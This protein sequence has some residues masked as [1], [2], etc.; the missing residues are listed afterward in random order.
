MGKDGQRQPKRESERVR[1][2]LLHRY[3]DLS[4]K[5]LHILV[6]L[7]PLLLLYEAGSLVYL[8]DH[9]TGAVE[10]IRAYKILTDLFG[11][12][13]I[14]GLYLLYLPGL[15]L[16][17]VLLA[18]HIGARESW[19]PRG[20]VVA[21]MWLESILLMLPLLVFS[22]LIARL[23]SL[24][25]GL[26]QPGASLAE[27]TAVQKLLISVGAGL[28]EEL[29]FRMVLIGVVLVLLVDLFA[30]KPRLAN[31]IAV[32]LAA[33]LFTLYHQ[34]IVDGRILWSAILLYLASGV[35]LGCV[36]LWRG[37]GI[38]VAVHALYDVMVLL[39]L[40]LLAAR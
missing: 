11:A 28:Y 14:S 5:P 22:Q 33:L 18:W 35:Y 17:A 2:M 32:A 27:M 30:V 4:R 3:G 23:G 24:E 34:P 13:G 40:P 9:A 39:I 12:I 8:T 15:A 25:T 36:F 19:R 21:L 26:V 1:P 7:L 20:E 16:L 29:L 10:K 38:V 6:F 31:V 37:F